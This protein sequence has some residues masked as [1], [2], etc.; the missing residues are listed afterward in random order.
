MNFQCSCFAF[1]ESNFCRHSGHWKVPVILMPTFI[2][3]PSPDFAASLISIVSGMMSRKASS[4]QPHSM[5]RVPKWLEPPAC[6]NVSGSE[7]LGGGSLVEIETQ[8]L[9]LRLSSRD[10]P[11]THHDQDLLMSKQHFGLEVSDRQLT[12]RSRALSAVSMTAPKCVSPH[13][14]NSP[15]FETTNSPL[16]PSDATSK[17]CL[18]E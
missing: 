8:S 2:V 14:T 15:K 3:V 1:S 7:Y 16:P 4:R 5:S 17:T 6:D 18:P 11:R 13:L 9:V 12:C 10:L